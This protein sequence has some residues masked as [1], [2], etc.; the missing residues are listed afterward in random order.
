V[1][2]FHLFEKRQLADALASLS[3][4]T[5]NSGVQGDVTKLFHNPP[6]TQCQYQPRF[7]RDGPTMYCDMPLTDAEGDVV[8]CECVAGQAYVPRCFLFE[9]A[10]IH[11]ELQ[12]LRGLVFNCGHCGPQY[13][14]RHADVALAA[15]TR[16]AAQELNDL[17][18][19]A[20]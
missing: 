1:T 18:E 10:K 4:Q 19:A 9:E 8:M 17:D 13:A 2:P 15:V 20:I 16:L 7:L 6:A 11:L 5:Q 14:Q 12:Y 3:M